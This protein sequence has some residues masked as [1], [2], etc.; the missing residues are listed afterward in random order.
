MILQVNGSPLEID[1]KSN[2]ADLITKLTLQNQRIALEV[3]R[4]IIP[5]SRHAEFV[6]NEGDICEI[7]KAVGG[8]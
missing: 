2:A 5:K 7:I 6:L 8:G 3:N 1:D 4:A